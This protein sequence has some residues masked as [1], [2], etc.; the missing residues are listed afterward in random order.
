ML[1]GE[2]VATEAGTGDEKIATP[3]APPAI[4]ARISVGFISTYGK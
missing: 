1:P 2:G 3:E 4:V